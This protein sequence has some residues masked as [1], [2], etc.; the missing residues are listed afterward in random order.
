MY[1]QKYYLLFKIHNKTFSSKNKR[2]FKGPL[3]YKWRAIL[4]I[5]KKKA[6]KASLEKF[7]PNG[8]KKKIVSQSKR[9][10]TV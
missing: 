8:F 4:R 3:T 1:F 10:E 7:L 9:Q 5:V 6:I 2:S